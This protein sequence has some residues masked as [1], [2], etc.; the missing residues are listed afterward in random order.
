MVRMGKRVLV[1][2]GA[3]F[4]GSELCA[5]LLAKGARV[6]CLDNF[7]SGRREF[8]AP[9]AKSA[10][11]RLVRGDLLNPSDIRKAVSGC[12]EVYH[13]AANPDVRLGEA[14]TR[15]HFEQNV[16]ATFNL[17]E[18]MKSAEAKRLTFA[19]SSV[20]YGVAKKMPTPEDYGP[21][22]P[23]SLYGASKL[24]CEALVSAYADNFGFQAAIVRYAN[25]IGRHAHGVT[26]DFRRKLEQDPRKLE[27]LGDGT[28]TKSYLHVSDCVEA[29]MLAA[30]SARGVEA[31]NIGSADR[32]NVK[33]IAGIVSSEMG[34]KG[35]EYRFTGGAAWAGDVKVM[36]LSI[37]KMKALGWKPRY[38]SR[39]AVRKAVREML[40]KE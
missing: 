29:T 40:G 10:R 20:V 18:E 1:T 7:S 17:L 14:D 37:R 13:M 33:D 34:L 36:L 38:G 16:L 3:G 19:S 23:V 12:A 30:R 9:F 35:V 15:V 8:I 21:L 31:F 25:V 4:I 24:A 27:I 2:G 5:R 22:L 26:R 32:L 39:Q 28:Q 6:T 11:F